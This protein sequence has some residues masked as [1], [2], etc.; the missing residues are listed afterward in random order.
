V[1]VY[2]SEQR[3]LSIDS[4]L[5]FPTIGSVIGHSC[6]KTTVVARENPVLSTQL[7]TCPPYFKVESKI[8]RDFE[9]QC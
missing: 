1:R 2:I 8:T 7:N 6:V 5:S 3:V 4:K 9:A